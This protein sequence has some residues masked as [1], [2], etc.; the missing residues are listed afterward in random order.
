V[1]VS[2]GRPGPPLPGWLASALAPT[3]LDRASRLGWGFRNE[4]WKVE[5][6][7]GR[8]LAVTRLVEAASAAS[9][10]SVV[11]VTARIGPALREAGLPT[12]SVVD[13]GPAAT[14]LLV[15]DFVDG[16]PGAELLDEPDGAARVGSILG[17]V[18]R[19]L[20]TIDPAGLDLPA[21]WADPDGLSAASMA[22]LARTGHR[23]TAPERARL[24]ADIG[25]ARGLLAVRTPGFVHGDLAPVNVVVGEGS[26]VA[27]LDLEF[28]RLAD[29]LLDAGWFDLIVAF[30]HPAARPAEW[31]A[32]KTSSGLD[33]REP[34]TRELLRILPR[35][36]LLEILDAP[37]MTDDQAGHWV[38]LLR[39]DPA[40]GRAR[41][42]AR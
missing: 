27:L 24:A 6:A 19:R 14:G 42:P 11:A 21:T 31:E 12:P 25:A 22:R 7:D 26:L 37:D 23:L 5:L 28:T 33:D 10:A 32:F 39:A 4:T 16:T 34:A 36:R 18:W 3:R 9:G 17:E 35:L 40:G 41:R 30:H 20:A 13:L 8:R 15:T 2:G 29:P 38:R 1:T